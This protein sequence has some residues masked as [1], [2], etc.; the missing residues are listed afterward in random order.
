VQNQSR[1]L[2]PRDRAP[3]LSWA[4]RASPCHSRHPPQFSLLIVILILIV[5]SAFLAP[6]VRPS[7]LPANAHHK[8]KCFFA[9][10]RNRQPY[11]AGKVRLIMSGLPKV[12]G[13]GFRLQYPN[14]RSHNQ[15][16][17]TTSL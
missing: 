4:V 10:T 9:L 17:G 3:W 12:K 8:A 14:R 15:R 11:T 6:S 5:I 1:Q 2:T 16:C 7:T 13:P